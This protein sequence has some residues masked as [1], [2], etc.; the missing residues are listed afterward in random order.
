MLAC[1]CAAV[2]CWCTIICP[3]AVQ[4]HTGHRNKPFYL[5]SKQLKPHHRQAANANHFHDKHRHTCEPV[6]PVSTHFTVHTLTALGS[7]RTG[8]GRCTTGSVFFQTTPATALPRSTRQLNQVPL[9]TCHS[10]EAKQGT[11]MLLDTR[12]PSLGHPSTAR[13]H[14]RARTHARTHTHTH[15]RTYPVLCMARSC[16]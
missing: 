1:C 13:A 10:A 8:Q 12:M 9:R 7:V 4:K 6:P 16:W 14:A 3:V 15:T 2:R 11:A 5:A